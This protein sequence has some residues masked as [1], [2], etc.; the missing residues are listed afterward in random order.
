[1]IYSW[2]SQKTDIHLLLQVHDELIF[3]IQEGKLQE[4]E[5]NLIRFMRETIQLEEVELEVNTNI[6]DTWAEAK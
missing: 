5:E 3:E 4:Y 2:L 1:K 6:G